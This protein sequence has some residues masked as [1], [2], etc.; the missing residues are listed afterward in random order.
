MRGHRERH[1]NRTAVGGKRKSDAERPDPVLELQR[2]IGNAA[3]SEL[4]GGAEA[5][6]RQST[7]VGEVLS[8]PG[9]PLAEPVRTD[10]EARLG[11]DFSDV[12]VHTDGAAHESAES[13]AAHAYTSGSHIVFQRGGY[14]PASD[15][16][17]H[18]LAHELTHV[19]QQR[20][21]PVAGADTGGGLAIS[22]PSDRFEREAE[23]TAA[24]AMT[25]APVAPATTTAA[26]EGVPVARLMSVEA[27]RRQTTVGAFEKRGSSIGRVEEA[28]AAYH[29]LPQTSY[30]DRRR[31]LEAIQAAAADYSRQS[32]SGRHQAT[33]DAVDRESQQEQNQIRIPATIEEIL[34][35][36]SAHAQIYQR[37]ADA[38]RATDPVAKV[39]GVLAAQEGILHQMEVTN[40]DFDSD[41]S[42][43]NGNLATWLNDIAHGLS[44]AEMRALVEDDLR[45]L[46]DIVAD[47]NAPQITRDIL[48]E[49]LAHRDMVKFNPGTPGTTLS[50]AGTA[51]KYTMRH[52]LH[53]TSGATE[54]IGSL[55]HELTHVDSGE[56]YA[57]TE[58]LLL[59]R[60]NLGDGEIRQL[61]GQ[62]RADI[63]RLNTLLAQSQSL[64]DRQ[65]ELFD[66]KVKYAVEP[67]KGV[68]RY[69]ALFK[70]SGKIDD[71]TFQRLTHIEQ[72]SAP[73]SSLLVE[74][75]P[76]VTQLLVYLQRWGVGQQDPLHA[77]VMRIAGRLR[78]DRMAA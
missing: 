71:P 28:L 39:R 24:A 63:D 32:K 45:A 27:F 9:R 48:R 42:R 49:V 76:V 26:G 60:R 16:G 19:I 25:G 41:L 2:L 12:R 51:E 77:E 34:R 55:A 52:M 31:Q 58:I 11:A 68:G 36:V 6:E 43:A 3:V 59:M 7:A 8:S 56:T 4:L 67:M 69:A 20:Q 30:L 53:Q 14:N 40:A 72:L 65:R 37:L 38:D 74:Y 64:T 47:A 1:E 21:G 22:D 57:N 18:V 10:M 75:D 61:V 33:V 70:S 78:N 23:R 62:R 29:R 15:A 17:R 73:N 54:R 44:A 5:A 35:Q 46:D 50:P 13:V 66:A